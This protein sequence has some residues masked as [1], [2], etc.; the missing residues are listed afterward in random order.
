MAP[1]LWQVRSVSQDQNHPLSP[2]RFIGRYDEVRP[3]HGTFIPLSAH[4]HTFFLP[5]LL[6]SSSW[7]KRPLLLL[8]CQ[9]AFANTSLP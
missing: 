5:L 7:K 9:L 3:P 6:R 8:A 2:A 1:Y 4:A